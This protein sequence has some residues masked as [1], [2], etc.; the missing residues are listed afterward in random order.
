MRSVRDRVAARGWL[1]GVPL[2]HTDLDMAGTTPTEQASPQ[3]EQAR[4]RILPVLAWLRLQRTGRQVAGYAAATLGTVG[5][6]LGMLG[7][8]DHTT[9]LSKGL[10][11]LVVVVVATVVGGLGPG[12][13]ASLLGFLSFE[14]F[15]LPPYGTVV[16]TRVEHDVLLLVFLGL[17]VLI[18]ALLARATERA[19]AAEA[20]E[21]E[22]RTLQALSAELVA[23]GPGPQTYEAVLSRLIGRF[24]YTAASLYLQDPERGELREQVT[25]GAASG[26]LP[27]QSEPGSSQ[28][29]PVRL[30]LLVGGRPMGLLVLHGERSPLAPAEGRVLRAFCDQFA[31]VL[32]R[33][34]LLDAATEAEVFR[35]TDQLRRSLLAAVSHDL[36]SPLAAIKASATDLL[37]LD[38]E[39][40]PD[41]LREAL[42]SID[43]EADRL[44]SLIANLLD[45]SRIEGGMLT[46]RLQNVDLTEALLRCVDRI[47]YQ[48]PRL[49][50]CVSVKQAA[51]LV[52]ADPVFL[53][54]VVANLLDNA[55]KA[56]IHSDTGEIELAARRVDDQAIVR[57]IDHGNGVPAAVREQLFYPFYQV[58]QRHPRLG[59]GLGLA[60]SKGFLSLMGG[61]I[62]VEDTPGG[63]VTF[64]FSL[65]LGGAR[66]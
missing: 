53:D 11:F 66:P 39:H 25:V 42:E 19:A 7:V 48:W 3:V 65:P 15:F 14:F 21:Q 50:V 43:T 24:G 2:L 37:A 57:V 28:N 54:R 40:G 41:A 38:V 36:R 5:F 35:R 13:L 6:T 46:A 12:L 51:S 58:T 56:A 18:S 16:L 8:R 20:R 63:G 4:A 32:E 33:D 62:W 9:L 61:Q 31:L 55:A 17:S 27:L 1:L 23:L 29:P 26:A 30:P 60:I 34:R 10:G 44:A 52:R 49:R 64:T 59:T 22:L 47:R 45:M